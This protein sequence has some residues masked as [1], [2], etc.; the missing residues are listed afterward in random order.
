MLL[1]LG[2]LAADGWGG[3]QD[4]KDPRSRAQPQLTARLV[5]RVYAAGGAKANSPTYEDSIR[6]LVIGGMF[7]CEC[8]CGHNCS[9]IAALG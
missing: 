7:A 6:R 3:G 9:I 2:W 5:M 4:K 1:L 8:Q